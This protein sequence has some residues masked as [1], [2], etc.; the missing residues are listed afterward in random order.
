MENKPNKICLVATTIGNGDFLDFYCEKIK[1][2][3]LAGN[4]FVIIIPR[5]FRILQAIFT[6][7]FTPL[8]K[9]ILVSASITFGEGFKMSISRL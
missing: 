4:V 2:E 3:K 7:I 5:P 1:S 8:G 6:S 9:F